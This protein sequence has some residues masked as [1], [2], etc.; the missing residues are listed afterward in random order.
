MV[1]TFP[2][3]LQRR[4]GYPI[5]RAF[6]AL[7]GKKLPKQ[8]DD[9]LS[10]HYKLYH[11]N[12]QNYFSLKRM[13]INAGFSSFKIDYDLDYL[14]RRLNIKVLTKK[15]IDRTPFRHIFFSNLYLIAEK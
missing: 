12:E 15:I 3:T 9:T 2:N 11:L 5:T 13:V 14:E 7:L 4:Y 1:F 6:A 8:Q 10:E